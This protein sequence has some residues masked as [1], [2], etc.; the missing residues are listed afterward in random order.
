MPAHPVRLTKAIEAKRQADQ[1]I[2][3]KAAELGCRSHCKELLQNAAKD[4]AAEVINARLE[5]TMPKS[6]TAQMRSQ[7]PSPLWRA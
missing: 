2:I 5:S 1:A 7:K 6:T 4:A 3:D